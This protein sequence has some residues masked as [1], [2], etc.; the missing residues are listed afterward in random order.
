MRGTRIF[1]YL[2]TRVS[3]DTHVVPT[4]VALSYG[5]DVRE[6]DSV[7]SM[8]HCGTKQQHSHLVLVGLYLH[9]SQRLHVWC[10]W[11]K[12]KDDLTFCLTMERSSAG[13]GD[14]CAW[15]YT[16]SSSCHVP[17]NTLLL[18]VSYQV[19]MLLHWYI[20]FA[21]NRCV[22]CWGMWAS[23]SALSPTSLM[24]TVMRN[25]LQLS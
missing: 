7:P 6:W 10:S 16:P 1:C 25:W 3:A 5:L 12:H 17:S 24:A 20:Q 23:Y 15:G 14:G 4:G 13:G 21:V 9:A 8:C 19:I 11:W 22:L 18:L 2:G